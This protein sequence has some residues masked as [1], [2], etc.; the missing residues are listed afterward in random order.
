M[1]FEVAQFSL[2]SSF[3]LLLKGKTFSIKIMLAT[4]LDLEAPS[5]V[6]PL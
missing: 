5:A 1:D 6:E 2:C 4:S 3:I